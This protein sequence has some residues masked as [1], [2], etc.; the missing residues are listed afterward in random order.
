MFDFLYETGNLK[1]VFSGNFVGPEKLDHWKET[2]IAKF[3]EIADND[4]FGVEV[5]CTAAPA[6]F[7]KIVALDS[8]NSVDD[9]KKGF[10]L[11]TSSGDGS[12]VFQIAKMLND[13]MLDLDRHKKE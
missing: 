10:S 1:N 5:Y 13:G 4:G 3:D 11:S 6:T 12:E 7:F 2:L 9:F 8:H